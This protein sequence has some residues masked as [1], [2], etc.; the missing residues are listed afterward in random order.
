MIRHIVLFS[1]KNPDDAAVI[2]AALEQMASIPT[3][4]AFEV[5]YNAKRDPLSTEIDVVLYSEFETWAD[6]DAYQSHP[7][8][9]ETTATVRPLRDQRVVVDYQVG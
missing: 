7:L 3:A 9:R 5:A 1:A 4:A 8:Y 6:L 2:K